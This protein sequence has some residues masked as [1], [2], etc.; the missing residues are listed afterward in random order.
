M[1]GCNRETASS[2]E[3]ESL[4]TIGNLP[5]PNSRGSTA[6]PLLGHSK[7][8]R[9]RSF[10]SRHGGRNPARCGLT[11]TPAL[12]QAQ[13]K[14]YVGVTTPAIFISMGEPQAHGALRTLGFLAVPCQSD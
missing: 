1:A 14:L 2:E 11:W 12:R 9:C 10:P 13:G 8:A 7:T 4:P 6:G 5:T 3:P